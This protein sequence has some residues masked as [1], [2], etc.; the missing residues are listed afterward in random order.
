MSLLQDAARL[1]LLDLI[2]PNSRDF[3]FPGWTEELSRQRYFRVVGLRYVLDHYGVPH[4]A[5]FGNPE[6]TE[7]AIKSTPASWKD[8]YPATDWGT[9]KKDQF[10]WAYQ[11]LPIKMNKAYL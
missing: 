1:E 5:I 11:A 9:F 10:S 2:E 7:R 8:E 4:A 6:Y 3:V